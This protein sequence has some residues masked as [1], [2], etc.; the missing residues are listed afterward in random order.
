MSLSSMSFADPNVSVTEETE[1][2]KWYTTS[3]SDSGSKVQYSP[4]VGTGQDIKPETVVIGEIGRLA[5]F[6]YLF[7]TGSTVPPLTFSGKTQIILSDVQGIVS[8]YDLFSSY[9]IDSQS[10]DYRLEQITNGSFYIGKSENGKLVIYSIDGVARLIFMDKG[11]EMTSM[12]LF[13]GSYIRFDPTRNASLKGADLFRIITTLAKKEMGS[14]ENPE[15]DESFEFVNPRV[16]TVDGSD[17]F[18]NSR[19]PFKTLKLFRVLSARFHAQVQ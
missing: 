19:L 16:D 11:V 13:P 14:D 15:S 3:L 18:F 12:I 17:V 8:L 6:L 9:T 1:E 4:V 10:G 2:N 7:Q 5:S